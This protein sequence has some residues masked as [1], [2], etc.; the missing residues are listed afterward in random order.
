MPICRHL[1]LI[2][3]V[4]ALM[5]CSDDGAGTKDEPVRVAPK[6]EF[7]I[8][9]EAAVDAKRVGPFEAKF[10]QMAFQ[11]PEGWSEVE[12]SPMQRGII[13]ARFSIPSD[14]A[15]IVVT[16]SSVRGG[17]DANVQ[18]WQGQFQ[19]SEPQPA[20]ESLD[21]GGTKVTWVDLQGT[22]SAGRVGS[23]GTN[24]NWRMLGAAFAMTPS[25]YYVKLTGP[26]DQV[27][28]VR[29]SFREFITSARPKN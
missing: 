25:D 18:R 2:A 27:A 9:A 28:K 1:V 24:E 8:K 12:L 6:M 14:G 21:V 11:V 22:F 16:C 15:D 23:G 26:K 4:V 5:G 19:S 17:I 20:T 3:C 29:D 10:D 7:G 13:E